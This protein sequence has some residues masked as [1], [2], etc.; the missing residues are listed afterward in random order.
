MQRSQVLTVEQAR[1]LNRQWKRLQVQLSPA[2]I[3]SELLRNPSL[4]AMSVLTGHRA[5]WEL[6]VSSAGYISQSLPER[7]IVSPT[8]LTIPAVVLSLAN[9]DL[10]PYPGLE[11]YA[12]YVSTLD[13]G[14]LLAAAPATVHGV[15]LGNLS[16]QMF[17]CIDYCYNT[18]G[19]NT[20]ELKLCLARC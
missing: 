7:G 17:S 11:A 13:F 3:G 19:T 6:V 20:D 1:S 14:T 18:Y 16:I 2:T 15:Q 8:E 10:K 4:A 9:Q 5:P 12:S